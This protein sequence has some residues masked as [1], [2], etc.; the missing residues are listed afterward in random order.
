MC[1]G[2][3]KLK[4]ILFYDEILFWTILHVFVVLGVLYPPKSEVT[5]ITPIRSF[6]R[7]NGEIIYSRRTRSILNEVGIHAP[8]AE[9]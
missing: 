9:F 5:S 2:G 3:R 7:A 6:K 4:S 8:S 1:V